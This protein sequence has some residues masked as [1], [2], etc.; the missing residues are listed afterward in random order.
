MILVTGATGLTGAHL[1]LHL[2]QQGEQVRAI[3]RTKQSLGKT[4]RLFDLYGASDL[5]SK[6]DWHRADVTDVPALEKAFDGVT[7][8]C[9]CAAVISFNREDEESLRKT[10]IEG[11]ANMINL[12]LAFGIRRFCHVSSV[13]AIGDPVIPGDT[14]TEECEWNPAVHY[15]DYAISKYGAEMEVWRGHQEGLEVVIVNPGII[16]GPGFWGTGSGQ[17]F[18]TVA[19]GMKFYTQGVTGYVSVWD[20]VKAIHQLLDSTIDG[21]RFIL[22]S[23]NL[24]YKQVID[25]VAGELRVKKPDAYARPWLTSLGW[26]IDWLMAL[27]GKRRMLSKEGATSLHKTTHYSSEKI[28]KALH[29]TFEPIEEAIR[30]TVVIES[31]AAV[32]AS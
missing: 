3:Y 30:K 4:Q 26:R 29:F 24:T 5:F 21:E 10:N 20:V 16:I 19:K 23:E 2:L 1:A 25:W 8:V 13:A 28:I 22:V 27:L 11:T 31:G 7:R 15:H 9:H 17:I 14:V 6:I 32:P 18:S 12:A